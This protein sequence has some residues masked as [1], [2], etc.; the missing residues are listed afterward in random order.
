MML[1]HVFKILCGGI[2]WGPMVIKLPG[3]VSAGRNAGFCTKV[4]WHWAK[5][6]IL[7]SSKISPIDSR[8]SPNSCDW[9][10]PKQ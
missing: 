9:I 5:C 7:V 1:R 3:R 10:R 6:Q 2:C 8:V 4:R